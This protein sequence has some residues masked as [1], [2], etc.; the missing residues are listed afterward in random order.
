MRVYITK[1]ALSKGI[2]ELE[3][4]QSRNFPDMLTG[5][6]YDDHYHGEGEEWHRTIESAV[7]KAEEMK[8]KKIES[9]K[10]QIEKLERMKF[11]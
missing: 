8:S 1:Y 3:V 6:R 11:Q 4:E 2:F 5:F 7:A 10:K 9:L